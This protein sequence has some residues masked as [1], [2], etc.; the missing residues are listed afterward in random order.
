[1]ANENTMSNGFGNIRYAS[2]GTIPATKVVVPQTIA[3]IM[4]DLLISLCKTV[5]KCLTSISD[6]SRSL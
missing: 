4:F 3:E 6:L 1:M 5:N 2:I